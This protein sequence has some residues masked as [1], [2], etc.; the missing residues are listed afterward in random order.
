MTE[1]PP[2]GR[3][4]RRMDTLTTL[5]Q[6][7]AD[8]AEYIEQ[9]EMELDSADATLAVQGE[10]LAEQIRR[11]SEVIIPEDPK[12]Q[13]L[14]DM[15]VSEDEIERLKE[16]EQMA[17]DEAADQEIDWGQLSTVQEQAR[18][19][20]PQLVLARPAAEPAL[21]AVPEEAPAPRK[22][23]AKKV[24]PPRAQRKPGG[25]I[26]LSAVPDDNPFANGAIPGVSPEAAV[27]LAQPLKTTRP[28]QRS[29]HNV[30]VEQWK[31][32]GAGRRVP[33]ETPEE[34]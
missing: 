9:L 28:R 17:E 24:N 5:L 7:V 19:H 34:S 1:L 22:R 29:Q 25:R 13:I 21:A 11:A 26:D 4:A 10:D 30:P 6:L 32:D 20:A 18:T 23:A 15:H 12:W 3:R 31:R 16:E 33:I 2:D 8:Q 27:V 14:R